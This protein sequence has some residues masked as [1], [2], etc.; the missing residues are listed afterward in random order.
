ML[1]E[2]GKVVQPE[3][4]IACGISGAVQHKVGMET[5][6]IIVAINKNEEAPIFDIADFGIVADLYDVVPCLL[7]QLKEPINSENNPKT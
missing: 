6:D 2:L 1:S 4:Y 5:S 3:L 7:N